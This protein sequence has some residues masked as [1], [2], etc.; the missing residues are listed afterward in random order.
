MTGLALALDDA[1]AAAAT[2]DVWLFRGRS[3]ADRAIQTVTNSPVNHVG[4]V[5]AIEDLPPLL[6]HAELGRSLEDVW[7]GRRQRGVQLHVLADAAT[8]WGQRYGQR[9]WVRQLTG[10]TLERHH[11][12]RLMEVIDRFDGHPF[13]TMPRLARRWVA[14][15]LRRRATAPLETIYCAELVAATYR[16]MGL[17]AGARPVSWYDPGAFWSGD[18]IELVAPF[19]LAGEVPVG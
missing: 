12:D 19:R 17:L 4:M 2:G 6:W 5:V 14:G 8:T 10:G 18:R 11:E 1:V 9:A 16:H 3:L 15:R 13:P 7:T